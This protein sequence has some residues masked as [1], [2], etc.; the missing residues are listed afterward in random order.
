MKSEHHSQK[1]S[2]EN[3]GLLMEN[4]WL[5]R[6]AGLKQRSNNVYMVELPHPTPEELSKNRRKKRSK[7]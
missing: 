3:V 6:Q 7:R 5:R 2:S 4:I 1:I